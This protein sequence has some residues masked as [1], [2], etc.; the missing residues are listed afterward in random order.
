MPRY[1][2]EFTRPDGVVLFDNVGADF[3]DAAAA[4]AHVRS[5]IGTVQGT[6]AQDRD[7]SEW[8]ATIRGPGGDEVAV[9]RFKDVTGLRVA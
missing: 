4:K 7:W 6:P 1:H 8:I 2:V 9:I 5:V 3:I